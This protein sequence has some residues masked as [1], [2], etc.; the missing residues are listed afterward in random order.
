MPYNKNKSAFT[1]VELIVVIVILAILATIAFLSF[2]SQSASARDSTRLSDMSNIAKWLSVF[3]AS[4][5]T[6]PKPDNSVTITASWVTIWYQWYAW[7]SVL[8]IAKLSNWWKDPLDWS[9][10]TYYTDT[11]KSRFQLLGFLEDWSNIALSYLPLSPRGEGWGEVSADSISYSWRYVLTKWDML[12]ILLK[13]GTMLPIQANSWTWVDIATASGSQYISILSNKEKLNWFVISNDDPSLV[14]YWD[15]ETMSWNLIKDLTWKWND[16]ICMDWS[17][18]VACNTALQWPQFTSWNGKTGKA[19]IFDGIPDNTSWDWIWAWD[20]NTWTLL[21]KTVSIAFWF[22]A[23][24]WIGGLSYPLR[25]WFWYDES[26]WVRITQNQIGLD[27]YNWSSPFI[28]HKVTYTPGFYIGWHHATIVRNYDNRTVNIYIDWI[29][30]WTLNY[31]DNPV[32]N[33]VSLWIWWHWW[34]TNQKFNWTLD[35]MR[36]YNRVLSAAEISAYYYATR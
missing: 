35:E 25:K 29:S 12:W 15:M 27:Y 17:T 2:S 33:W 18:Q 32:N 28:S 20:N 6:Y 19:M 24:Q 36:I 31:T 23:N 9:Y 11:N 3:N 13:T 7:T 34:S 22:K 26:Y 5:W 16:W 14:W 30:L 4:A 1:L 10:Y 21:D 8:G